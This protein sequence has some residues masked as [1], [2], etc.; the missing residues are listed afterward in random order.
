MNELRSPDISDIHPNLTRN[1]LARTKYTSKRT[2]NEWLIHGSRM[3]Y[4]G[5]PT[6]NKFTILVFFYQKY[7]HPCHANVVEWNGALE[8]IAAQL[9]AV[10]VVLVPIHARR[11][12]RMVMRERERFGCFGGCGAHRFRCVSSCRGSVGVGARRKNRGKAGFSER[13]E[14][15][16][17]HIVRHMVQISFLI[18]WPFCVGAPHR[19]MTCGTRR[20]THPITCVIEWKTRQHHAVH[21]TPFRR[22]YTRT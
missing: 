12:R 7:R 8:R 14:T 6:S 4:T 11:I 19:M 5:P 17:V 3:Y 13:R 16:N 10:C 20:E 22:T 15:K 1:I 18:G 9:R 21:Y 2:K